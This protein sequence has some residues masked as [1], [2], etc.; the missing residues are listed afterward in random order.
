[1]SSA[2]KAMAEAVVTTNSNNIGCRYTFSKIHMING[3]SC[4]W[5]RKRKSRKILIEA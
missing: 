3:I 2:S 1:V 4:N 5:R